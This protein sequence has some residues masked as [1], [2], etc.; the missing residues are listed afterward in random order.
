[1]GR[2]RQASTHLDTPPFSLSHH[3][4]SGIALLAELKTLPALPSGEDAEKLMALRK[5]FDVLAINK[6]NFV[7]TAIADLLGLAGAGRR[8]RML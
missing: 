1:L 7:D 2:F 8:L 6:A 5:R 4:F 3:P